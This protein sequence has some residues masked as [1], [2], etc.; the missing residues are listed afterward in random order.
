V[1]DRCREGPTTLDALVAA[2]RAPIAE[3]VTA[4]GGLLAAG[5]LV[6]HA[7]WVEATGSRLRPGDGL[8]GSRRS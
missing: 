3:V 2:S 5:H 8:S 6:E 7:G 4:V 1:L